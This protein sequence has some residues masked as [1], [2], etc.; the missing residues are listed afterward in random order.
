M[1]SPSTALREAFIAQLRAA[2]VDGAA[3][4]REATRRYG[5]AGSGA[6]IPTV[7]ARALEK[8]IE[9]ACDV[10]MQKLGFDVLRFSHPGKTMQTEGISDRR[11]MRRARIVDSPRGGKHW[12]RAVCVWFEA[13]SATGEQRPGQALF[14]E[15]VEACGEEYVCGGVDELTA[16]LITNKIA[17]RVGDELRIIL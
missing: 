8:Q 15:L 5:P 9:H 4:E 13:K 1:I 7:D 14:E 6:A 11:Y 3:A 17:E 16:W 12:Q 2:N 10:L